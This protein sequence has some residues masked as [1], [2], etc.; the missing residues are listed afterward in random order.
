M[1]LEQFYESL[2]KLLCLVTLTIYPEQL[3]PQRYI[4]SSAM[5]CV[6]IT[7]SA[8]IHCPGCPILPEK[9]VTRTMAVLVCPG[10]PSTHYCPSHW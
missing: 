1:K 8:H 10:A 5:M 3:E 9:L 6:C 4:I 7:C 2:E